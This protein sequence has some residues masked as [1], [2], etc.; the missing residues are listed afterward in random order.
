MARGLAARLCVLVGI[1]GM[2][3]ACTSRYVDTYQA[4][5]QT[6]DAGFVRAAGEPVVER[7]SEDID[8]DVS[9]KY[10]VGLGVVGQSAFVG[11]GESESG[12]VDQAR[13][14]GAALVLLDTA[15]KG[16][17]PGIGPI[18]AILPV[19]ETEARTPSADEFGRLSYLELPAS[20]PFYGRR[21]VYTRSLGVYSQR[22]LYFEPLD[23]TGVGLLF[24]NETRV[25]AVRRESPAAQA[26]IRAGDVLVAIGGRGVA[27]QSAARSALGAAKG[28]SIDVALTRDG[29]RI[30]KKMTVPEGAW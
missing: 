8:R 10:E 21:T 30:T 18:Q 22:A 7:A 24:G 19:T 16:V 6:L 29:A 14:V 23:R 17:E 12:A 11:V 20:T 25:A 13:Q 26:D 4:S 27:N 5:E 28:K 1:M 2:V 9:A 3:A 15:Y